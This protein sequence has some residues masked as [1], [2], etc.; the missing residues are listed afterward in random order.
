MY[1]AVEHVLMY[2]WA[3]YGI[4][5]LGFLIWAGW[6]FAIDEPRKRRRKAREAAT[7][8]ARIQPKP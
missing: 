6:V 4:L 7:L 5:L 3:V 1:A 8:L 2:V